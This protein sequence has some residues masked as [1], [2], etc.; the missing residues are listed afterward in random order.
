[1]DIV[2][3]FKKKNVIY[4]AVTILVVMVVTG[5]II[6]AANRMNNN[7]NQTE[8]KEYNTIILRKMNLTNAIS[9]KGTIQSKNTK[10]VS[11]QTSGVKVKQV[12]VSVG[13]QIQQGTPLLKFDTR[14]LRRN[15]TY[16]KKNLK[17]AKRDYK[18]SVDL[19]QTKLDDAQSTYYTDN[20]NFEK[21]VSDAQA[22]VSNAQ[23]QIGQLEQAIAAAKNAKEKRSLQK[24]LTRAQKSQSSLQNKYEKAQS[25]HE[26]ANRQ[27]KSNIDSANEDLNNVKSSG[28]KNI[29]ETRKQV[30]EARKQIK[31]CRVVA[32]TGG[33]IT[34]LYVQEDDIYSGGDIAQIDDTSSF[35]VVTSVNEY[36]ISSINKGQKVKV[37]TEATGETELEGQVTFVAPSPE[38]TTT[39][40][41]SERKTGTT[42]CYEVGIALNIRDY[43]LRMGMTANCSIIL[44]EALD[45]FAVPYDAIHD[46]E[47]GMPAIY[48]EDIITDEQENDDS[49]EELTRQ[50]EIE[51]TTGME[52]DSYVEISSEELVEGLRII[53]P[54]DSVLPENEDEF[55]DESGNE[56]KNKDNSDNMLGGGSFGEKNDKGGFNPLN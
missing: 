3:K 39:S 38:S 44:E 26:S 20:A 8:Q 47:Y 9:A 14:D 10:I 54:D 22:S 34:A 36:N 2:K 56:D 43:R 33:V 30:Q 35:R 42:P 23:A 7:S 17:N 50:R 51:V 4:A 21:K 52:S 15:L 5:I 46:N 53:M 16:A 1:M 40:K 27:N 24:Q 41:V 32:S 37:L 55:G 29:R 11:A 6:F 49:E 31:N 25:N 12:N 13:D 18:T 28:R 19:A 48:V 45:V